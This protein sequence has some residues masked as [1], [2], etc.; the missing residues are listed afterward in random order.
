MRNLLS[1]ILFC[2]LMCL[3]L[4]LPG[5]ALAESKP[6]KILFLGDRGHHKPAERYRQLAPELSKRKIELSYTEETAA[7]SAKTLANY[8]GLIVY[9]NIDAITKDQEAA[10]LEYVASGKGF[11]P[12]HCASFCFR[13][14]KPYVELVGAQFKSHTTGVFRVTQGTTKDAADHPIL[15]DFSGFESWDETYVHTM[16]NEKDRTVLEYRDEK[17]SKEP[18]TWVRTHGKGRVFYTAWGH[19][20]RTW[21]HAGFVQ[22]VERGIRWAC[23]ETALDVLPYRDQPAMVGP[24]KDAKQPDFVEAKIPFYPAGE[25]WGTTAE[26]IAK[27]PKALSPEESA[28]HYVHPADFEMKLFAS[29]PH[30]G[31]KP[32]AMNWDEQGRLWVPVTVDYPNELKRDGEGRDKIVV[33]EDTDGDG[34]ADKY[35]VFADKLS[36]PT[37]LTF[38]YGG[39]IVHQAPHTL[40][41]RDTN[42]DGVADERTILLTG[43]GAGDTHA[44]PSNLRYGHDGWY[45]GIVG[46]SAFNG[47]VNGESHR[48]GQG[49]YRFRVTQNAKGEVSVPKLEFLRGT[50]NNSWGVGFSEEGMLFAST[51]NGCPSVYLPIPNRYYESVRGWSSSVLQSIAF[52]NS[53]HPVTDKIRQVDHHHGFTAAAGHALYT[54]REYPKEYWNRTAFVMEP[55][56]HLAATMVLQESG[57]DF[58]ARYGWNLV[59]SHDEWAAPIMAEVGPDGTVWV[60]DWYNYI[61]QHNPTPV[62]FK[63]GKGNAYETDVR[64]KKHGRVYRLVPKGKSFKPATLKG[65][66]PEQLVA[67]LG[68]NNMFWRLHAQ[69]L[70]AESGQV[71]LAPQIAQLLKSKTVDEIGLNVRAIHAL[72]TLNLL[73]AYDD[74]S[75]RSAAAATLSHPSAAVRRTALQALPKSAFNGKAISARDLLNDQSYHVRLAALLALA[76][77]PA[78]AGVGADIVD[79]ML[80]PDN[81]DDRWIPDALTSAAATHATDVLASL[82]GVKLPE[83]SL[84]IVGIVAEHFA[85]TAPKAGVDR[86]LLAL[87][88]ADKPVME[89]A[90]AAMAKGW[91]KGKADGVSPETDKAIGLLFAQLPAASKGQLVKLANAMGSKSLEKY[92]AEIAKGLLEAL[93]GDKLTEAQRVATA[94]QATEFLPSDGKVVEAILDAITPRTA[95]EAAVG[96]IDAVGL[97]TA[98]EVGTGI[99]KRYSGWVPAVRGSALRLLLARAETTQVLL[100]AVDKGAIPLNDLTL[101]QKQALAQHP[102]RAIATRSKAILAKGGSLPNADRQKVI[103]ELLPNLK[104]AG[105]SVAGKAMFTKHCANCHQ[106]SGEGAKIGPDLT[107]MAVHPKEELLVHI[108][109]PSRS[110]EGNFRLYTVQTTTGKTLSGMLASETKTT[111][112]LIDTQAKRTVVLREEIETLTASTKSLMPEG[113]EKQM[114]PTE[115]T[116]LLEFL[117]KRGKYLPIPLDKAATIVSTKGMFIDENAPVERLI[118]PDWKPKTVDGVPFILIDPQ[119]EKIPN[120]ILLNSTNGK[121]AAKMPR[122]ATVTV[123]SPAKAIHLLGGIGGWA[124]PY[125]EK[126]TVSLRVRLLYEDGKTEEHQLKNGEQIADYIRRVDVPGSKFA[127][128]LA[129]RQ[130]RY[131]S[132][133]PARPDPIKQ[134]EFSK[135]TDAVA[136]VIFAVTVEGR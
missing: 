65:A 116:N 66:T 85:R 49:L 35:S 9:A 59:A 112:E 91:P 126:G 87:H 32:I 55:T 53:I 13:N 101:D 110:V 67:A 92:T 71:K 31:G 104:K 108:M 130:V 73:G 83:K 56:G 15:K 117:T 68:G 119:G 76:E 39:I 74:A 80:K 18:W 17:G 43:W 95:P 106:H 89:T 77:M 36:I 113:F 51:A 34:V 4:C 127:F 41:L 12:L 62:G 75:I 42:G 122:S 24:A 120:V 70:I 78:N 6:L 58:Q 63:T 10:L 129:G 93:E 14:S 86:V 50:N 102:N 7:L 44:G 30:F 109:D 37:S 124:S 2:L 134:I 47:T 38:A 88:Q 133:I 28:K 132:L 136:P 45:Y 69:R 81:L 48:F 19:D 57:S 79:A 90:L 123:N 121:I 84:K 61:V 29:E 103:E 98:P 107:G 64:D 22:L 27:M 8:D 20:E 60:L 26:P 105:D 96:F 5:A 115:F 25:K 3:L 128:N 52:S 16:H 21:A 54:A 114:N 46:Y 33:C 23:G 97:S 118:F 94:K 1:R 100:D 40:F 125:G 72:W 111:V 82:G 131:L 99:A 135:G 11:I